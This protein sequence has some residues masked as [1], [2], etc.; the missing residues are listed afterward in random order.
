MEPELRHVGNRQVKC[1]TPLN[2]QGEPSMTDV[3]QENA[4]LLNAIGLKKI[5]SCEKGCL[6]NTASESIRWCVFF[7]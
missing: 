6:R 5:L 7:P 4:P 2:A 3:A 1:H